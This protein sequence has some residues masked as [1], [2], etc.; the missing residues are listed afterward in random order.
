MY[1]SFWSRTN[2]C[3]VPGDRILNSLALHTLQA[4][5]MVPASALGAL[6]DNVLTGEPT[7]RNSDNN[8]QIQL[9]DSVPLGATVSAKVKLKIWNN[10]FVDLKFLLPNSTE[11]PLSIMVKSGKIELQQASTNKNPITIH[12]WTDAYLIFI[13][14]Y[15]QKF[16]Q[17]ASNLLK[18]M[19]QIREISKLHGD[20]AWRNYDESFRKIRETSL[21]P[22]ERVVT[23]LRLKAA[24]MGIRSPNKSQGSFGKRQPF[25]PRYCFAY[26]KGQKCISHPCKFSHTCQD[27]NGPH[28][29]LQCTSIR[30]NSTSSFRTDNGPSN[31]SKPSKSQK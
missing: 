22:W 11:E 2:K 4:S 14:I 5:A 21:L 27:C 30:S 16:P 8:S 9:T 26:N 15:L 17:E 23:E 20:Q 24:S 6:L 19:Y 31:T 18:Y 3:N 10:E 12:Q 7:G 29:R 13:S 28:P 1:Q 25:R